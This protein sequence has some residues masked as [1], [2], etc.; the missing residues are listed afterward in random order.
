MSRRPRRQHTAE[1]KAA[2][3]RKHLVDKVP[4]SQICN[5]NDLQPSLFYDWLRQFE[6]Q[7]YA[8]FE[9]PRDTAGRERQLEE[10]VAALEARLA[11][12]DGVIAWLA[13]E[14]ATLKKT[15]G[16]T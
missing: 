10:K 13:Q 8:A 3:V 4:V 7:A 16:E 5:E 11:K 2:L 1:Q 6:A 12:K 15:L 9:R 14:H